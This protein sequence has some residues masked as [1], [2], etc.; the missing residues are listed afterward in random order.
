MLNPLEQMTICKRKPFGSG[1]GNS[2]RG[3]LSLNFQELVDTFGF[4]LSVRLTFAG[5]KDHITTPW[6]SVAYR[7]GLHSFPQSSEGP[8]NL[9]A[10]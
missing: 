8:E 1:D 3:F 7:S 9:Q 6:P 4:W 5:R 10:P 2:V